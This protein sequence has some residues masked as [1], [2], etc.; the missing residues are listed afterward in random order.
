MECNNQLSLA[1]GLRQRQTDAEIKLWYRLRDR[2]LEGEKFR[3]QHRIGE[4]IVD[5]VCLEHKLIIKIDGGQHNDMP[6]KEE[7]EQ[8]TRWLETAGYRVL[9]YWNNDILENTEGVLEN[10]REML[11]QNFHPHL[12][13]PLKGEEKTR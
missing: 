3:R 10:I 13:S 5:F 1:K 8:R 4:Y 7:D 2:Q 6:V 12:A 11:I 9:R